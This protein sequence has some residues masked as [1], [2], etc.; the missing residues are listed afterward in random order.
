M[1][2]EY[3]MYINGEWIRPADD[4]TFDDYNPF[5]GEVFARVPSGGKE[6]TNATFF[7][8]FFC[9]DKNPC[10]ICKNI[11]TLILEAIEGFVKQIETLILLTN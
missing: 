2:R 3:Q 7:T 5:T 4:K 1:P 6:D 10:G 9:I 11:C 8:I